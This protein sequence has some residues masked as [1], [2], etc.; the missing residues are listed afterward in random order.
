MSGLLSLRTPV[1]VSSPGAAGKG[2]RDVSG[3]AG[4]RCVE[5]GGADTSILGW[6]ADRDARAAGAKAKRAPRRR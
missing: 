6:I 5:L 3:C 4:A 2:A 1:S